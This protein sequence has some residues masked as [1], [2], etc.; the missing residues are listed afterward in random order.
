M[1]SENKK[2][3]FAVLGLG[4]GM[5][6]AEAIT[7]SEFASLAC[8]CDIDE[9][10]REKFS[11]R[12]PGIPVYSDFEDMIKHDGVDVVCVCLPTYMHADYARKVLAAGKHCLVEKPAPH[13]SWVYARPHEHVYWGWA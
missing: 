7:T 3:S 11:A 6:H 2:V 12:F 4:I 9:K 8:A 1:I 13:L 5:A 10:R